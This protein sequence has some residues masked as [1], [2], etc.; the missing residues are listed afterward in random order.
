MKDIDFTFAGQAYRTRVRTLRHLARHAGLRVHGFMSGMVATP[1]F[2]YWPG[3]RLATCRFPSLY[4]APLPYDQIA[5][6]WNRSRISYTPMEASAGES[7]L[8][9]KSRA[10]EQG[11]SGTLMVCRRSPG[12]DE[13][14][15]PGKEFVAFEDLDDCIEKVR[16]YLQHETERARIARAYHDR[17]RAQH[18]WTHRFRRLFEDIGLAAKSVG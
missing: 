3:L 14:Y 2:L 9:I 8:Q 1:A 16:Y 10:F 11:L 13:F 7:I 18:M 12:L 5:S 6:I 15:E 4:G 17:T